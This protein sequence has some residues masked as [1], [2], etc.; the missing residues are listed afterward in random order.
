MKKLA[1]LLAIILL[2]GAMSACSVNDTPPAN[3]NTDAASAIESETP[4][5]SESPTATPESEPTATAVSESTESTSQAASPTPTQTPN[6]T[7]SATGKPT[8][9]PKTTP[10][11]P[12]TSTAPSA[13]PSQPTTSTPTVPPVTSTPT[14]PTEP[15]F[16]INIWTAFAKS[17]GQQI[18]LIYDEGTTG[19]WDTP[20][21]ASS[22]SLY[23]ER[24][25]KDRLN[26]YSRNGVQY[27]S[28]WYEDLGDGKYNIYIGYA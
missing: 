18:G 21:T 11:T 12:A 10:S 23:L 15:A 25:I 5:T 20:I 14:P 16:D 9:P 28:V 6:N 4:L 24:D 2:L 19:S 8:D 13:T 3:S 1:F 27:F 26:R 7:Q 17:Y 22:T